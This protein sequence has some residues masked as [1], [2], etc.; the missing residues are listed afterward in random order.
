M[1]IAPLA[2]A[3]VIVCAPLSSPAQSG[4]AGT[5]PPGAESMPPPPPALSGPP[6]IAAPQTVPAEQDTPPVEAQPPPPFGRFSLTPANGGFLRF[7]SETGE[8]AFCSARILGWTCELA[9]EDRAALEKEIGRLQDDVASLTQQLAALREPPPPPRPPAELSPP[10]P[11]P[12]APPQKPDDAVRLREDVQRARVALENAW[13]R[14]VDMLVNF[15]KDLM[16]KG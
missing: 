13:Q 6:Q 7:D 8:V 16:R 2:A 5:L 9:A 3:V 10:P 1:R 11:P 4:D 12:A 14:L 15:Q